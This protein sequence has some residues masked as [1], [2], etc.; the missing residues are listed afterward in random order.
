MMTL[1][2]S[3]GLLIGRFEPL[4][5][6]PGLT[7]CHSTRGGGVSTGPFESLNLGFRTEDE[8]DRVRENRL[9]FFR[10]AGID[11]DRLAV[12]RQVHGERVA[13]VTS[14]GV[15]ADTD[16]SFTDRPGIF[17]TVTTA[18]CVPILLYWP[19]VRVVGVV[20]AG[21]R[22]TEKR[23]V[24]KTVRAM[25]ARFQREPE[26][27]IAVIGPCISARNYE[28]GEDVAARFDASFVRRNGGATPHLDLAAANGAQ[29]E[30]AG[31]RRVFPADVCTVERQ[32]LFFSH[33]GSDGRS[34]RMMA[35]IG[36]N[37]P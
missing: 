37:E 31:V 28:V 1:V 3:R 6:F 10:A 18:D 8:P 21:W 11:G 22:G 23:I 19:S 26:D 25:A 34:G 20:H 35:I 27:L 33:R 5:S 13:Y 30:A 29:L 2:S 16:A 15:F 24:E 32:D 12:Q 4:A 9:R 14:P 17:L 36:M 7:A